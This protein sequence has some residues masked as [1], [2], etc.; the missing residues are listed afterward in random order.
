VLVEKTVSNYARNRDYERDFGVLGDN[1]RC[2]RMVIPHELDSIEEED[3]D[4]I[5]EDD[6]RSGGRGGW[7]LVDRGPRAY[8][9]GDDAFIG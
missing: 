6:E 5:L 4:Q 2:I 9:L 3:E 7:S 8:W 1:A